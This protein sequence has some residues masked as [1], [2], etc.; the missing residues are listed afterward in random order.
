M[1]VCQHV[2]VEEFGKGT[3]SG[4]PKRCRCHDCGHE[5]TEQSGELEFADGQIAG[6]AF[7]LLT[8]R[9]ERR[10]EWTIPG[11]PHAS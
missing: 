4:F 11:A 3:P 5:W 6:L 7:V 8:L 1:K 9:D 10:P 2:K